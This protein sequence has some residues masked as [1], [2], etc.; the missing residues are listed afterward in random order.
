MIESVA[1]H[2]RSFKHGANSTLQHEYLEDMKRKAKKAGKK[3]AKLA[4][5]D[6]EE[7]KEVMASHICARIRTDS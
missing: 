2:I 6:S 3:A 5:K 1:S 4:R 7:S